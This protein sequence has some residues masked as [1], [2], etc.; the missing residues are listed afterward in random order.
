MPVLSSQTVAKPAFRDAFRQRRCLV[1]ADGFYEWQETGRQK[2]P[3]V[4]R[5]KDGQPVAWVSVLT[6]GEM[7]EIEDLFVS[8]KFR[9]QGIARTMMSRALEICARS[10]FK[11]VFILTAKDNAPAQALYRG[12]GFEPLGELVSY[13]ATP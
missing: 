2:Q 13:R 6:V 8:T 1:P 12:F 3:F 10:L 4:I 9:R 7:G 11:H 5:Q